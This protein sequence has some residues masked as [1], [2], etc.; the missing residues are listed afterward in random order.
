MKKNSWF[1]STLQ[2]NILLCIAKCYVILLPVENAVSVINKKKKKKELENVLTQ[3][4]I[5]THQK[6]LHFL[7]D[8]STIAIT[9]RKK[10]KTWIT[11]KSN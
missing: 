5:Q 4:Q 6:Q 1:A 9:R 10:N 2:R 11:V 7:I 3:C 8:I